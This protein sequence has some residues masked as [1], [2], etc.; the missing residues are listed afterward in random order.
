MVWA[1]FDGAGATSRRLT[2]EV[3]VS[4]HDSCGRGNPL[5]ELRQGCSNES[6]NDRMR[7]VAERGKLRLK[8][9][10]HEKRVPLQLDDP[11]STL[12]VDSA[13]PQCASLQGVLV[14]PVEAEVA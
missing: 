9:S 4:I 5:G 13:D 10:G 6:R 14:A 11:G 3:R 8:Q 1:G 12:L 2:P 7:E